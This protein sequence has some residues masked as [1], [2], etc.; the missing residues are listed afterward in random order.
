MRAKSQKWSIHNRGV[1]RCRAGRLAT[2]GLVGAAVALAS[3]VIGVV[4]VGAA[5]NQALPVSGLLSRPAMPVP[6]QT[7]SAFLNDLPGSMTPVT[8]PLRDRL[9]Q[10][11]PGFVAQPSSVAQPAVRSKWS[12]EVPSHVL[13]PQGQLDAV[14]CA[15]SGWCL[16][17]G[18]HPNSSGGS[19]AFAEVW[20]GTSWTVQTTPNPKG[21]IANE[22]NAVSCSSATACTAVGTYEYGSGVSEALV[23][24]W[25]GTRWTVQTTPNPKGAIDSGLDGVSCSSA[26]V[27]AA[28]GSY[29]TSSGPTW[30]LAER[31]NGTSW[32]VQTT[33]NPDGANDSSLDAVS[34]RSATACTAVGV[35]YNRSGAFETLAE[36]W[37]GTSWTVQ[38]TPNIG[39]YLYAV[40]CSSAKVCTAVGA[41][42]N[43]NGFDTQ[44][45][46]AEV[47]NGTSW[48]VQ[49]TPNPSGP[50]SYLG[51]VSCS[52]ATAC[53]A[54]GGDIAGGAGLAE[55][56]N[57]TSWT[58]QTT[59]SIDSSLD[60]VSCGSANVCTAVGGFENRS[61]AQVTLA[62]VWNGTSWT[63]QT[64]PNPSGAVYGSDLDA[65]SCRSA[66]ACT[67]V[68]TYE[69]SSDRSATLAEVWNGTSWTVQTTPN[70]EGAIDSSLDAVSCS[71]ATT[72]TAVGSYENSSYAELTLAE[73]WNGTSWTVQT[74]PNP[75]GASYGSDLEGVSCSST[76][77][78]TAVGES[79]DSSGF[80]ST[81]S[82]VW[83]GTSWTVLTTPN[84]KGAIANELDA[85]SC[86]SATACTAVGSYENSSGPTSALAEAWNG[87]SWTIQTTPTPNGG[88][89][90]YLHAVSC[91]STT[92]CTAVGTFSNRSGAQVTLAE[93]WNGTSWTVQTTPSPSRSVLGLE[94]DSELHGVS[95]S[96]ATACTA[97]GTFY[98][99]SRAQVTLA[100]VWNG[101]SWTVQTTPNPSVAMY[102]N[103][104]LD[105]VSCSSA[106]DCTA[107]GSYAPSDPTEA[108]A[109]TEDP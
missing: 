50:G 12:I 69:Y 17:V 108:F 54:V 63:V 28:V 57:G 31:W 107:V 2:L 90:G 6:T 39:G 47:W 3:I 75:S 104:G 72:C 77:A 55:V 103:S 24:V 21:A 84:R 82:E 89:D 62:E 67:A 81:L 53:T 70:P 97:V 60:G 20:N 42:E 22:L 56:W 44:A 109:E 101:T 41:L 9:G 15:N 74:T 16:A 8:D 65:V 18:I 85:V 10:L 51:G 102:G 106:T 91:R 49:T 37:N 93:R 38:T 45:T 98:N 13:K 36:V 5:P 34:C 23:E 19:E 105:A 92:A 99:R 32:T 83:N 33:A 43:G 86:R 64:T 78:C 80:Y 14:A 58:V 87:T 66:T 46:L 7:V 61:G 25:N 94:P 27:C 100:E 96:S 71:S 88:T 73:A 35:F 29:E 48:T 68:G 95:C 40:S 59:P 79:Q 1:L 52:S 11:R 4:T 26:T 76:T 30:A